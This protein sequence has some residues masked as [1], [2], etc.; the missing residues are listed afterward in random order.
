M[1]KKGWIG[2][3]CALLCCAQ[4]VGCGLLER[5]EPIT[6]AGLIPRFNWQKLTNQDIVIHPGDF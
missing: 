6:A 4:L 2:A 1:R 5:E 3:L